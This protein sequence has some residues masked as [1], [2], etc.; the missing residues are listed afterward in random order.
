MK[1]NTNT[2]R[3]WSTASFGGNTDTSSLELLSLGDHLGVCK[4]PNGHLFALH[5]V[6]ESVRGFMATRFVTT[7]VFVALLIGI[8]ALA[9]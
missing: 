9:S 8:A 5:C 4:S 1:T 7:L 2:A 3:F 6:V